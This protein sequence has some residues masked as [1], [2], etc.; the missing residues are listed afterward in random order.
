MPGDSLIHTF[1][2]RNAK[3]R[4]D[5]TTFAAHRERITQIVAE[6][7]S[8]SA[9]SVCVLG[10]GNCTDL[11]LPWLTGRFQNVLLTDLDAAAMSHGVQAQL[12]DDP[13]RVRRLPADVTNV[14]PILDD[15]IRGQSG[16]NERMPELREQLAALPALA[17]SG[18]KFDCV[19]STCLL[20]Q[21]IDAIRMAV[22]ER[23]PRF[24]EL[25]LAVRRQHIAAMLALLASGGT[26][27]LV[28]DFTSSL[29]SPDLATVPDSQLAAYAAQQ[30]AARNFFTG[31]N[32]KAVSEALVQLLPA[33]CAAPLLLHPWRWNLVPRLYLVTAHIA[34]VP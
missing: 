19:I 27:I 23:D 22:P 16:L 29:T 33:G 21:L 10:A 28:T 25:V 1:S 15:V 18:E 34:R 32:P 17:E 13:Q 26:L 8:P 4:A 3:T 5:W 12:G 7:A 24:L 2:A 11:D 30:V 20:S 9:A 6:H 14:Y 31:L